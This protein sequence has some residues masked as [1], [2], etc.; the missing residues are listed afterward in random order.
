[1]LFRSRDAIK[2]TDLYKCYAHWARES[3]HTP[4]SKSVFKVRIQSQSIEIRKRSVDVAMVKLNEQG[5]ERHAKIA[6]M[7]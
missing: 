4:V 1:V 6:S 3:G 5:N 2:L 7:E